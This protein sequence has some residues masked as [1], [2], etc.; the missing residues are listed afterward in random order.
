MTH[1]QDLPQMTLLVACCLILV[2]LPFVTTYNDLLTAGAIRLGVAGPLQSVSPIEARM[3]VALLPLIGVHGAAGG[4]PLV[5][6]G[7][8]GPPTHP[9]ISWESTGPARPPPLGGR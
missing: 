7:A 8:G 1:R 2:A 5:G 4:R 6:G 9:L 3:G